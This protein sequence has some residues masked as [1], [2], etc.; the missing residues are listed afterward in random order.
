MK[1]KPAGR[2]SAAFEQGAG[3]MDRVAPRPRFSPRLVLMALATLLAMGVGAFGYVKYGLVRAATVSADQLTVSAV[4]RGVFQD[5]VA[6]TGAV[7]PRTS[8]FL[9][10]VD[11]GQV[12]AV[13]V[14]QGALVKAGQPLVRLNNRRLELDVAASEAQLSQQENGL[15]ALR[16]SQAQNETQQR[17]AI[18]E[19][20]YQIAK[21]E[22]DIRRFGLLAEQGFYPPA[23]LED[24]R[25]QLDLQQRQRA[26]REAALKADHDGA[27]SQIAALKA[28]NDRQRAALGLI[29]QGVANLTVTA[30]I[31]GQLTSLDVQPGQALGAGQRLGQIDRIDSF[32]VV[33]EADEF[34]LGRL[35]PGQAAS[36][37]LDGQ[38]VAM[39]VAKVYPDVHDRRFQVDLD[40]AGITPATLRAGQSLE[41]RIELGAQTASLLVDSGAFYDDGGGQFVF[42]LA[43]DGK[44]AQRRAVRLGRR[45]TD[46]VEVLSGLSPGEHIVTSGYQAFRDAKRLDIIRRRA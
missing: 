38:P 28:S 8:V 15:A 13:L 18:D 1:F 25:R 2:A 4:R 7:A 16:L 33:V 22:A 46:A 24:L 44:T 43:K 35:Q 39:R 6:S 20:D 40:F 23:N 26:S 41:T 32:K 30:P 14:E 5:Y 42:V 27:Q 12:A 36:I 11:G 9:D 45:T 21:L 19:A 17:Q 29:H 10:S 3:G 34:Y 31:A 37:D